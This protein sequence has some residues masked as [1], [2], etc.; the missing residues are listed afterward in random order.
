MCIFCTQNVLSAWKAILDSRLSGVIQ[1]LVILMRFLRQCL[2]EGVASL[3][4]SHLLPPMSHIVIFLVNSLPPRWVTYFCNGPVW[5]FIASNVVYL[6]RNRG[7]HVFM[8][9]IDCQ[10][11]NLLSLAHAIIHQVN[12]TVRRRLKLWS[13]TK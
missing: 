8:L 6:F 7:H 5:E 11:L 13:P 1:L 4:G 10:W 9:L 2:I 12:S 3:F